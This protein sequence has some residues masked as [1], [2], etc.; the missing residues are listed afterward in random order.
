MEV[1]SFGATYKAPSIHYS[2]HYKVYG[3]QPMNGL[4]KAYMIVRP[5]I[6]WGLILS[7]AATVV[8]TTM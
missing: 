6:L 7:V 2:S 4:E 3:S 8:K 5:L 1:E